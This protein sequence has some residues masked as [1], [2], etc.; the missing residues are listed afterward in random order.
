MPRNNL[1]LFVVIFIAFVAMTFFS[2]RT[3]PSQFNI[4]QHVLFG[5]ILLVL[6]SIGLKSPNIRLLESGVARV[7]KVLFGS[8]VIAFLSW[9]LIGVVV[10]PLL[11][12]VIFEMAS[13]DHFPLSM[14]LLVLALYPVINK[15]LL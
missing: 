1:I 9:L 5:I 13:T 8:L 7:T 11:G 2:Y 4:I 6:A 3:M 15:Y 14:L 10:Q 12:G